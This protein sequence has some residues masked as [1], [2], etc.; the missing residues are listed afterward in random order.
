M[1]FADWYFHKADVC[2]RMAA[3]ATDLAKRAR[4][5]E[6]AVLWRQIGA[7]EIKKE[8]AGQPT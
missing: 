7:D 5:K 1:S 4:L 3:T 2:A 6:E 8:R